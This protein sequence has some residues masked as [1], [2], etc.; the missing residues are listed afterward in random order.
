MK[1][2]TICS[3]FLLLTFLSNSQSSEWHVQLAAF[4]RAVGTDYF[5]SFSGVTYQKDHNDIHRYYVGP[6]SSMDKA[7]EVQMQG[8]NSG[9]HAQIVNFE[10]IREKCST[11]CGYTPPTKIQYAHIQNIFFDF[12]RSDLRPASKDQLRAL[13]TILKNNPSYTTN[14]RAHTDSKGDNS[15]NDALS[16][17]RANAARQYLIAQGISASRISTD[18]FGENSPIAKN[19]IAGQDTEQ[20]RQFNRRVEI[21]IKDA[22]GNVLNQM[23]DEINVPSHLKN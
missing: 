21:Q 12:D 6:Y 2:I 5:K 9:Y 3:F 8:K 15:Y 14:L 17:R 19:E 23:V 1:K 7:K 13:A 10:E 22:S 20:G 18:T 11:A 16:R 4:D